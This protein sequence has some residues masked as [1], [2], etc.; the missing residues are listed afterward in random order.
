VHCWS[1]F[2]VRT[3]HERPWTHT[4]HHGPDLGE[5]STFP[6]IVYSAPLREA[7]IQMAFCP[8]T[9]KLPTL[10]LPQLCGVITLCADLRSGWGMKKRCSPRWELSNGVLHATCMQGNRVD[11]WLLMVGSQTATL[12][13]ALSFGHN[14]CFKCPNGSCKPILDIYVSIAFQWYKKIFNA[15]DFDP[16]N[17]SLKI[18]KVHRDSNSQN[19]SSL[20]S[21]S[22]HSHTLPHS[23]ASLLAH[24]LASPCLGH[25][26]KARVATYRIIFP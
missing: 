25:E 13:P 10:G 26:P 22:V 2:G 21:V 20:G 8:R 5:A 6:L 12:T 19:G 9:P 3:N 4:T 17:H 23:W 14:L 24:A 7:R 15:M 11:S 18:S 16:Y 1:T